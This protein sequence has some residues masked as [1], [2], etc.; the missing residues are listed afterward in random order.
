MVTLP[1]CMHNHKCGII[2]AC[3]FIGCIIVTKV[4]EGSQAHET[5]QIHTGDELVEV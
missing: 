5:G 4:T 3:M 2:L 1:A